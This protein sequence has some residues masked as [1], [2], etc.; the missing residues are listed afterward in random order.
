MPDPKA[1]ASLSL[2]DL[3]QA[4][5]KMIWAWSFDHMLPSLVELHTWNTFW[6]H[7]VWLTTLGKAGGA[8]AHKVLFIGPKVLFKVPKVVY[9]VPKVLY[10]VPKVLYTVPS[11]YPP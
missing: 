7:Q 6:P 3:L 5:H 9:K 1:V 2:V 4:D 11:S 8:V 10:I